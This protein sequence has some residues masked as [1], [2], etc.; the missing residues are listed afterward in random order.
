MAGWR[1]EFLTQMG[2]AIP[3]NIN[4]FARDHRAFIPRDQMVSALD[5]ADVLIWMTETDDDQGRSL[6]TRRSSQLRATTA[7]RNVFTGK[8]LAGAIAF[9]SPLS[10]PMV[11]DQL[12]SR[13]WRRRSGDEREDLHQRGARGVRS[14]RVELLPD[15]RRGLHRAGDHLQR[16]RDEGRRVRPDHH[17]RRV[18]RL[19][20]HLRDRRRAVGGVRVQG[21]AAGDLPGVLDEC[22]WPRWRSG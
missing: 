16:D 22:S 11:A 3:D 10:Y 5:A 12:P 15:L 19:P 8:D 18:H 2:F 20:A 13:P 14:G 7:K 9:S 4:A 1:T 21:R 17:R 6:P